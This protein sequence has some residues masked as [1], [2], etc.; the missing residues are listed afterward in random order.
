MLLF[1]L[2]VSKTKVEET[3]LQT[4]VVGLALLLTAQLAQR[5]EYVNIRPTPPSLSSTFLCFDYSQCFMRT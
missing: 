4:L 3:G 5:K 2:I 1:P